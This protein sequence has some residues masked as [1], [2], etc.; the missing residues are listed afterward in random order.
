MN[1]SR[2]IKS[3]D[4]DDAK[5]ARSELDYSFE[6]SNTKRLTYQERKRLEAEKRANNK[7]TTQDIYNMSKEMDPLENV[8]ALKGKLDP[9]VIERDLKIADRT[10][11]MKGS[12]KDSKLDKIT[13]K[14]ED[15]ILN[16]DNFDYGTYD[17]DVVTIATKEDY[18]NKNNAK[19]TKPKIGLED[20][21][22]QELDEQGTYI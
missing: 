15:E 8:Q 5:S 7:K 12:Q 16:N 19:K 4:S 11:S 21:I 18:T 3:I 22:G 17:F 14:L 1:F 10:L 20:M 2:S 6:S 13:S 9:N